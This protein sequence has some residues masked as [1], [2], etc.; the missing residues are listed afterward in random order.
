MATKNHGTI[1]VSRNGKKYTGHWMV[2]TWQITV[3]HPELGEPKT[4]Q[5]GGSAESPEGLARIML[6]ELISENEASKR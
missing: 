2:T 6:G 4:T 5:I 1:T 3:S